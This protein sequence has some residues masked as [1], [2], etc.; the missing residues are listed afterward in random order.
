MDEKLDGL[1]ERPL[2]NSLS[3]A[4][5]Y[6][7]ERNG[8]GKNL[9]SFFRGLSCPSLHDLQNDCFCADVR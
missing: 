6:L 7:R 8:I 9:F 4:L 3:S 1:H 2:D 5:V